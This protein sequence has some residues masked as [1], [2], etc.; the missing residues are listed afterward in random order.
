MDILWTP[1]RYEYIKAGEG[2]KSP[3]NNSC[4]FCA[5]IADDKR[6]DAE[7]FILHRGAFNFVVLNIYPY[8]SGHLMIVPYAHVGDLDAAAKEITDEMMDLTK[9]SQS[10]LRQVYQPHGFNIGMNLGQAAGAGVAA[11]IHLHVLPRWFGDAN[12]MTTIGETRVIPEDLQTTYE[13][14]LPH[15]CV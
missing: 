2:K 7:K 11:H 10:A 9:H 5:L 4:V 6:R 13:K 8:I 3:K 12:F 15:F 1:W 14:I